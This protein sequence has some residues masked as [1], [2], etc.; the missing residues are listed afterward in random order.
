MNIDDRV[1][2]QVYDKLIDHSDGHLQPKINNSAWLKVNDQVFERVALEVW[3]QVE[4]QIWEEL[5]EH[6]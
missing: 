1:R 6:Q 4:E 3:Y 5:D 2:D